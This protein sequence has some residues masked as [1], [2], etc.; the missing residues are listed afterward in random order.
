VL[1]RTASANLMFEILCVVA[2]AVAQRR[3]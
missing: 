3:T 2:D 1:G